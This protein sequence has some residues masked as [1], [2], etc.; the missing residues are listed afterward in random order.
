MGT[1]I[2]VGMADMNIC[3]PPDSIT[4]LGL[5]S[6]VGVV[7]YDPAKKISGMVHVMLPDST[8]IKNNEN[9]AKFADTGIDEL[10]RRMIK[11][12][13]S[14]AGL[15]AKIAGGAQMFAFNSN[16]EMLNVGGRKVEATKAKLSALRIRLLAEDTGL[17]YGRTIEFYPET[18]NLLIKSVGKPIKTI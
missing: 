16:S 8:K 2:K 4:T 6:C 5:G 10:V 12:G 15:V 1:M 7:I 13:A 14:R 17:N 11:A 18:G 9:I 3:L